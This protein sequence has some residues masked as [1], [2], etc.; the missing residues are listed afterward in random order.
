MRQANSQPLDLPV[1]S[2]GN[3]SAA[4][5]AVAQ[6]GLQLL[7][8]QMS[9]ERWLSIG[10]DLSKLASSN[11]WC[12]GDW[13]IYGEEFYSGRYR[14]AIEQ[15]SLDYQTLRNYAWVARRFDPPRRHPEL[16]FGH[17]AEV[18][19]LP[20]PEQDY[21]LRKAGEESWS[22]N[23]LRRE[24]RASLRYRENMAPKETAKS[25][26]PNGKHKGD[27]DLRVLPEANGSTPQVNPVE[28]SI[29]I[30]FDQVRTYHAMAIASRISLEEW[31]LKVLEQA[32]YRCRPIKT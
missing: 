11:A 31:V 6:H 28:L 5:I 4:P 26:A 24:L 3:G 16:S 17:H 20:Q 14:A 7:S 8:R 19:G 18:A 21:W 12:L 1:A 32:V 27:L 9:F 2:N 23:Y 25:L 22:R 13:L 10:V 29:S 15:T 30:P